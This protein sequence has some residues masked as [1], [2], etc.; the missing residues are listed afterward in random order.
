MVLGVGAAV[1]LVGCTGAE[2][3]GAAGVLGAAFIGYK[4][5]RNPV[6]SAIVENPTAFWQ[7]VAAVITL[8]GSLVALAHKAGKD[9]DA[10]RH[11]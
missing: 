7:T 11:Q 6:A 10:D 8:L 9:H 1:L 4:K 2:V 5:L 3:A